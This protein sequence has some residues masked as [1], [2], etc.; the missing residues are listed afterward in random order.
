M[1][2]KMDI[3]DERVAT[4]GDDI[5]MIDEWLMLNEIN[6]YKYES[7]QIYGCCKRICYVVICVDVCRS[8]VKN[9]GKISKK[10]TSS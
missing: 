3:E 5:G 8:S 4:R 10:L 6:I 9:I 7:K 1:K 2:N